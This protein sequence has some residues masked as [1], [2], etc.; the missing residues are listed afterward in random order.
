MTTPLESALAS[1]LARRRA[2]GLLR[3]LTVSP[4][5][6][7]DFSSNDYLGLARSPALHARFKAALN[8]E[9]QPLCGS[10]GS[11]L[12]TGN[13]STATELEAFLAAFHRA[14]SALLFN[15]GYD[16]NVGL[17]STVAVPGSVVL[18]DELVHASVHDGM[19]RARKSVVL[20]SFRHNCLQDLERRVW[21]H[22]ER[23]MGDSTIKPAGIL[24][25]AESIYSMD[26]DVAPLKEIVALMESVHARV[27]DRA[28]GIY[29]IV[30][31]AH[32]TGVCGKQGR[33]LVCELGL[34]SKVFA[35]LHTF[36]KAVGAHGAVILGSETLREYLINYA[37]PLIYSTSLSFHSLLAIKCA[38]EVMIKE[39]D[40]LQEKLTDLIQVF[41][42]H[43]NTL[44][45]GIQTVEST[46]AIQGIIVP[47]NKR[48]SDVCK[49][50]Q[51]R[52]LDVRPIRSPTV[53]KGAE[54][55]RIC[56]HAHNSVA[57]IEGLF[58]E[59]LVG[60][61]LVQAML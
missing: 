41:R 48:V 6:S 29:L 50:L 39:A 20:D 35:R 61:G 23:M 37:R 8:A 27:G 34:E 16:A 44:P 40:Q 9:Q 28:G 18:Y 15:S 54:R 24:I 51:Q 4:S 17:L 12:L 47:G 1:A 5:A 21:T 59:I 49:H 33:G 13:N 53:P 31:E 30:D 36:G 14:P 2:T 43:V 7:V 56:L 3:S 55:L 22:V 60:L 19:R 26:G 25:V 38:Y 42:Q 58:R 46:T 52:G 10:T 32:S 45:D 57:E 11:R